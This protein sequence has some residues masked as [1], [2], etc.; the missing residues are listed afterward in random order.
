VRV[1]VTFDG[2]RVYERR[3]TR[4]VVVP[5]GAQGWH[6]I[7]LDLASAANGLRVEPLSPR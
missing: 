5:A 6:L 7:G 4:P 2:R 1:T 3:V